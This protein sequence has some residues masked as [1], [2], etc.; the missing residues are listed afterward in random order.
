[1]SAPPPA[2]QILHT[3]KE[4]IEY[5]YSMTEAIQ[6]HFPTSTL[7]LL[8]GR[9]GPLLADEGRFF[10][11]NQQTFWTRHVLFKHKN[12]P[13]LLGR[14]ITPIP[15]SND[16]IQWITTL[17]STPL[18]SRLFHQDNVTREKITPMQINES[19]PYLKITENHLNQ[20]LPTLNARRSLFLIDTHPLLITEIFLP[21]FIHEIEACAHP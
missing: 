2:G 21:Y 13:L 5:P 7:E 14:S 16:T 6:L 4:W 3:I 17:G 11:Q 1:M 12:N 18:G 20:S 8:E 19:H 15:P 9:L 10:N